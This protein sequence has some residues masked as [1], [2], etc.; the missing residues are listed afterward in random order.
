MTQ[1]F[2]PNLLF[3]IHNNSLLQKVILVRNFKILFLTILPLL[4]RS[5]A[6][7]CA[8]MAFLSR[9]CVVFLGLYSCGVLCCSGFVGWLVEF[10]WWWWWW[11]LE[12][13]EDVC[14]VFSNE[15]GV[16]FKC[17][18]YQYLYFFKNF[19]CSFVLSVCSLFWCPSAFS[20]PAKNP[21]Q[22]CRT[23]SSWLESLRVR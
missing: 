13:W 10:F 23:E 18:L 4:Q 8:K 16:W 11:I 17:S 22:S 15:P 7:Y 14:W 3:S 6:W 19:L 20:L 21:K 2:K 5:L 9:S 1:S 12:E